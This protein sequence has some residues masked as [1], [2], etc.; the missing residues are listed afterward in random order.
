MPDHPDGV[1]RSELQDNSCAF[2]LLHRRDVPVVT[3]FLGQLV[4]ES[5]GR[6]YGQEP[7]AKAEE[8]QF[9]A[10]IALVEDKTTDR[11]H[12]LEALAGIRRRLFLSKPPSV[13]VV[14]YS[15]YRRLTR[16]S[17]VDYSRDFRNVRRIARFCWSRTFQVPSAQIIMRFR[18]GCV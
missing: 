4:H 2:A 1:P 9:V 11:E 12:L 16:R 7:S 5:G 13:V 8:T 15:I 10:D 17:Y 6:S 3:I 18:S 14:H